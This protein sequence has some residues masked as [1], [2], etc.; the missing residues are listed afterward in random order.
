A[1][2]GMC[3]CVAKAVDRIGDLGLRHWLRDLLAGA[4]QARWAIRLCVRVRA[5]PRLAHHAHVPQLRRN[6]A[7]GRMHFINNAAPSFKTG[8][9][10][11]IWNVRVIRGTGPIDGRAFGDDQSYAAFGTLAVIR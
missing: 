10:M 11:E 5:G 2:L 7:A 4:G 8:S 1:R 6:L 9:S 3:S